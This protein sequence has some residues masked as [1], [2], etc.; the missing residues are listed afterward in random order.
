[1]RGSTPAPGGDFVRY[2]GHTSCIAVFGDTD[3]RPTLL[4]DAGTGIR[5]VPDLLSGSAFRGSILLS[6]L[7]WDH[8]MGLPFCTATDRPDSEVDLYLP[9]QGGLSGRDLLARTMSPP[10]FPIEPEGLR[11]GWRFHAIEPGTLAVG[12]FAVRCAELAHK[13][14]RTY[15]YR[16]VDRAGSVAY[17]PDHCPARRCDEEVLELI[18]GVDVLVH[19]AQFLDAER[20][21]ADAFGHSTVGDAVALAARAGVGRLVL[22][23][24]APARTD[25]QLDDLAATVSAPMPVTLARQGEAIAVQ[26]ATVS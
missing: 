19:D 14:G 2:G 11:G 13:G 18:G 12:G 3:H 26:H 5:M 4:L 1:V 17:L 9:A 25:R 15:G 7:H 24:H 6:H 22:F 20:Q 16:I 21:V 8:V 23:H 10:I